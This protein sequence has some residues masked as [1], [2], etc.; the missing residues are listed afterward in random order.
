MNPFRLAWQI[1]KFLLWLAI[2]Y[3]IV[4]IA[5]MKDRGYPIHVPRLIHF[6]IHPLS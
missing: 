6:L 1:G 3:T 4:T 2:F 5:T